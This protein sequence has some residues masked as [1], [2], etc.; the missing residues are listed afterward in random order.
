[1]GNQKHQIRA[2]KFISLVNE[3]KINDAFENVSIQINGMHRCP[4]TYVSLMNNLQ[5]KNLKITD[6]VNM[7]KG[8]NEEMQTKSITNFTLT[9]SV[10]P[11]LESLNLQQLVNLETLNVTLNPRYKDIHVA[12]IIDSIGKLKINHAEI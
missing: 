11:D 1:M 2:S 4:I 9:S 10:F 5:I 3:Y 12:N 8:F 7:F 6:L